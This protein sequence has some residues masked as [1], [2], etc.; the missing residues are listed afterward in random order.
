[1]SNCEHRWIGG[2]RIM[3]GES[4]TAMGAIGI[5]AGV[6]ALVFAAVMVYKLRRMRPQM[7]GYASQR[8]CPAC[9]LITPRAKAACME[10]GKVTAPA[11]RDG[12]G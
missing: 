9:G 3:G 2:G 10:C 4:R 7:A 8:M 6:L 1:M 12:R 11:G 5:C